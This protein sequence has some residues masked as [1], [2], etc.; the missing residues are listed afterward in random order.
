MLTTIPYKD[1]LKLCESVHENTQSEAFS[2]NEMLKH[3]DN[4]NELYNYI[5][6]TDCKLVGKGSSR[7]AFFLPSG[8]SSKEKAINEPSCLKVA[9]ESKKGPA[10][11]KAEVKILN[12]YKNNDKYSIFPKLFDWDHSNFYFMLCEV[13]APVETMD[14][15]KESDFFSPI[16][17]YIRE[18]YPS[19]VDSVIGKTKDGFSF[20]GAIGAIGGYFGYKPAREQAITY[21]KI[22]KEI[23]NKF[24]RFKGA[25]NFLDYMFKKLSGNV[26]D[27]IILGDFTRKENWAIVKRDGEEILIPIDW[28]FTREV[29]SKYY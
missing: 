13:G 1:F 29:S 12:K 28:G 27:S 6:T 8:A 4:L 20:F 23:A 14:E 21:A 22:L 25:C 17:K 11:N 19:Y 24:P 26:D 15:Q 10:Q 5:S 2:W 3:S 16:A 7:T 18:K 9:T